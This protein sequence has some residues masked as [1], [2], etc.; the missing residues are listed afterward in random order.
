MSTPKIAILAALL[1]W[2]CSST[3]VTSSSTSSTGGLASTG[4]APSPSTSSTGGLASTGGAPSSST[5][6]TGG[7]AS[8]GGVTSSSTSSTGGFASTGGAPSSSTTYRGVGAD[9]SQ[10]SGACDSGN[11]LTARC[12]Q[13]SPPM[14]YDIWRCAG[15]ACPDGSC[16]SSNQICV[17]LPNA[18]FPVGTFTSVGPWCL[19]S[20]DC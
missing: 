11:C 16:P 3:S 6:S 20:F 14:S 4:G 7:L 2:A 19:I 13:T 12:V 8:T 9:C 15:V 10:G 5:S 17:T 1:A 18:S